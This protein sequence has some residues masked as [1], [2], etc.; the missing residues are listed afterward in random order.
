M[1][2]SFLA[3]GQELA[4]NMASEVTGAAEVESMVAWSTFGDQAEVCSGK[5]KAIPGY[6]KT[7]VPRPDLS[8]ERRNSPG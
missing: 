4:S 6:D 1:N 5:E 8:V 3:S 7:Y 2:R